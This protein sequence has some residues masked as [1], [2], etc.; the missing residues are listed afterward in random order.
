MSGV[1]FLV[2]KPLN[3]VS[4]MDSYCDERRQLTPIRRLLY[5]FSRVLVRIRGC[6]AVRSLN[7][8]SE[9]DGQTNSNA[10]NITHH[11]DCMTDCLPTLLSYIVFVADI[12]TVHQ[13]SRSWAVRPTAAAVAIDNTMNKS[14]SLSII[15]CYNFIN[16]NVAQI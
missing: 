5:N 9:R 16:R 2:N 1:D 4:H 10:S 3:L 7:C 6:S 11:D 13:R 8:T 12:V 14:V 15:L